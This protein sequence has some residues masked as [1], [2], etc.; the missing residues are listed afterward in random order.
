MKIYWDKGIVIDVK[1]ST[2]CLD[3]QTANS[4]Y[5][6]ILIS[7]AHKDHTAGFSALKP[8]KYAT[9][10]TVEIYEAYS[11]R[12]VTN[13]KRLKYGEKVRIE[14]F[15]VTAYN[16]GHILGSA[17]FKIETEEETIV[18]TGDLNCVN[19]L[20][21][22]AATPF[23][24]DVLIIEA[25]YGKPDLV[26]PKREKV[27]RW[28]VEWVLRKIK[29]KKVPVFYV[30]PIGKSQEIIKVLNEFTRVEVAVHPAIERVNRVYRRQAIN[31]KTH[32]T[33]PRNGFVAVYPNYT[34]NRPKSR[35]EEAVFAT[36]WAIKYKD[37]E[38]AFP[39]SS[40]ADFYQLLRFV[41]KAKPK[42]VYTVFGYNQ[43]LAYSIRRKLGIDAKPIPP[44]KFG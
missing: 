38:K 41:E 6:N 16:S 25:T 17:M 1:G 34:Y 33:K 5:Q 10:Q 32:Q 22:K 40:H 9:H 43:N 37:K 27:Y 14:D 11:G 31:L 24:C 19:T 30:Y 42:T 4:R 3:P 39:L 29:E 44:K 23:R 8:K 20:V 2:L 15:E 12:K 7:H 28:I 35:N 21:T 13:V 18:Y 36:G 26:F